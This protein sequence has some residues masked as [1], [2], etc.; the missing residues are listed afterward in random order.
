MVTRTIVYSVRGI[1]M[2][3][4]ADWSSLFMSHFDD[5]FLFLFL[6]KIGIYTKFL[7]ILSS[8]TLKFLLLTLSLLWI[9]VFFFLNLP[10]LLNVISPS[11]KMRLVPQFW[12][13]SLILFEKIF[14]FI[15]SL[16]GF[17]FLSIMRKSVF[18]LG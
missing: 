4:V 18:S 2:E 17:R 6:F 8:A 9:S 7:F 16:T 5:V 15:L 1:H 3:R 14:V 13:I 11:P 10:F 12:I